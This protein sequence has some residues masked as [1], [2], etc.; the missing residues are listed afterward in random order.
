MLSSLAASSSVRI[1]CLAKSDFESPR[2]VASRSSRSASA[3]LSLIVIVVLE[4]AIEI[5]IPVNAVSTRFLSAFKGLS[6]LLGHRV[7]ALYTG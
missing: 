7:H 1:V 6:Y 3:V 2:F 5:Q 4:L